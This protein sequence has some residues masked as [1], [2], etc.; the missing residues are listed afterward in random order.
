MS[1]TYL[2][3][4]C[5][6]TLREAKVAEQLGADRLEYCSSLDLDGLT[7]LYEDI[8]LAKKDISIPL[9]VMI[10]PRDGDFEYNEE[11]F[12]A[13]KSEIKAFKEI[14]VQGVVFGILVGKEIDINR[15]R[16]LAELAS[17]ME[18]CFHKAIDGEL[19]FGGIHLR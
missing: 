5:I 4:A 7:P 1:N 3:E 18:V 2:K 9:M 10:R 11:E 12:E 15:T 19:I 8:I 16:I 14:G 17:P 6:E 13:M